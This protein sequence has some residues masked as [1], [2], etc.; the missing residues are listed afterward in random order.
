MTTSDDTG[1]ISLYS[2]PRELM[3]PRDPANSEGQMVIFRQGK[4]FP[5]SRR[6]GIGEGKAI[7]SGR[8]FGIQYK[9]TVFN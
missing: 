2:V 8:R 6:F 4:T 1:G 7:P 3:D 9:I 5:P